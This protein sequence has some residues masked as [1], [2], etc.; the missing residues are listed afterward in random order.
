MC[1]LH[2]TPLFGGLVVGKQSEDA[3]RG[4]GFTFVLIDLPHRVV[5]ER[6]AGVDLDD[7]VDQQHFHD[8]QHVD[9][10]VAD[11]DLCA[12]RRLPHLYLGYYVAGCPSLEYK[13]GFL[14]N[15]VLGPDGAWHPFR[16]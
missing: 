14:P 2:V 15:E 11:L 12:A 4:G 5:G 10:R 1:R 13:A 3:S 8:P 16:K 6:V 7:V 9:R